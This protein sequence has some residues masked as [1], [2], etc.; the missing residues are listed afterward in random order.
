MGQP[1]QRK[2][3]V[4]NADAK[5]VNVTDNKVFVNNLLLSTDGSSV[6]NHLLHIDVTT[7]NGSS[8][9]K[10]GGVSVNRTG[11]DDSCGHTRVGGSTNV[12]VG[13]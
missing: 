10:S 7:D 5:I 6:E 12:N 4:N 11:D 13:G 8:T 1:A 2:T 3:D 9:V